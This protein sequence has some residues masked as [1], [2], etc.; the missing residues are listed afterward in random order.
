[1]MG[2]RAGCG[3]RG[4]LRAGMRAVEVALRCC[5]RHQT[6][7]AFAVAGFRVVGAEARRA[8]RVVGRRGAGARLPSSADRA[9]P[10]PLACLEHPL[11][12]NASWRLSLTPFCPSLAVLADAGVGASSSIAF[13]AGANEDFEDAPSD[14]GPSDDEADE[15]VEEGQ[16]EDDEDEDED[17]GAEVKKARSQKKRKT[18]ARGTKR[19]SEL[20]SSDDDYDG[21]MADDAVPKKKKVCAGDTAVCEVSYW[22]TRDESQRPTKPAA[23]RAST[24]DVKPSTSGPAASVPQSDKTRT[25]VVKQ[26]TTI[27]SSIFSAAAGGSDGDSGSAGIEVRSAAFAEEV[28]VELFEGFAEVDDKGV[29]GPRAKYVSKFRSLHFNLKSNAYLRSRVANNELGAGKLIHLSA[30]DLQTPELRAMAESVRA[31]SLR[32]SVKEVLAAPTAKRTHKGE[33]EIDNEASR[34]IAA[35][36]AER[37]KEE[38]DKME[39]AQQKKKDERDHAAAALQSPLDA[40]FADS[41]Y[42]AAGSPPRSQSPGLSRDSPAAPVRARGSLVPD[43]SPVPATHDEGTPTG[44]GSPGSPQQ[45]GSPV[46]S[47]KSR[48]SASNFD[49]SSI[50]TKAKAASPPVNAEEAPAAASE[51]PA[52]QSDDPF[53][54]DAARAAESGDDDFEDEL[55]RDP[56]ASPRKARPAASRTPALDELPPIWAGDFIVPEEGGFPTFAV[57]LGGRPLG[58][59]QETWR[60]LLP[61]GLTTAGRVPTATAKKYLIDCSLAPTRE[62]VILA[63]LPDLTGPS[64]SFPHKPARDSCL[65]KHQHIVDQYVR[66]DR[67]GVVQPPRELGKLVKDIYVVPLRK[68]DD[69]P[70]YV[71]LADEHVVPPSR[72]RQNDLIL[73]ILVVQKGVLPTVKPSPLPAAD[74]PPAPSAPPS[75]AGAPA[76]FSAAPP[77]FPAPPPSFP[78]SFGASP[79]PPQPPPPP[80]T[81]LPYSPA[82][83]GYGSPVPPAQPS[84][85]SPPPPP[86]GPAAAPGF[87]PAAM[88]SLLAQVNPETLNSLLANPSLLSGLPGFGG[89][90]A[91]GPPPPQQSPPAAPRG[92]A[93]HPSRLALLG[94]APPTGPAAM[95]QQ[96]APAPYG[97]AQSDGGWGTW[98][99]GAGGQGYSPPPPPPGGGKYGY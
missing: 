29:R 73:A 3:R 78:S 50:W 57:Q 36:Q 42:A 97:N 48:H 14:E 76:P 40:A 74:A 99:R 11:T 69:I 21:E 88:Q 19:K 56:G 54:L 58:T 28:E 20:A 38:R 64:A 12:R 84:F 49:M 22:L 46:P 5:C 62:L 23:R 31:A 30:E 35:E 89:P 37:A 81:Q 45:A 80:P 7:P 25:H 90:G 18:A 67:V 44:H 8:T 59:A 33:E 83:V 79:F 75:A 53:G 4:G 55:F 68:G 1:M 61:K 91:Q 15:T 10:S 6:S 2:Q 13:Y 43:G 16:D 72:E 86:P 9:R 71:E 77:P 32:N 92:P 65:A 52:P 82:H 85:G 60:Q 34:I 95:Q 94:G 87:D 27:F 93:V 39:V 66:R 26:L 51:E 41:P 63:L 98:Q 17:A 24:Q 70:D 96:P 47:A